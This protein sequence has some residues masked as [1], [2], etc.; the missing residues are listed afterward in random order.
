MD[1]TITTSCLIFERISS[2]KPSR[3][4]GQ[5]RQQ[6]EWEWMNEWMNDRQQNTYSNK[7][8]EWK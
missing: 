5:Q 1:Y 8:G 4:G 2:I 3:R 7:R 6:N